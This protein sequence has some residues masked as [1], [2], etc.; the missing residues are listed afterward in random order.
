[1]ASVGQ[2]FVVPGRPFHSVQPLAHAVCRTKATSSLRMD[3][4]TFAQG[5]AGASAAG[6]ALA[7][8]FHRPA[9]SKTGQSPL[10][11]R[12]QLLAGVRFWENDLPG[13][14]DVMDSANVRQQSL[15]Q[16]YLNNFLRLSPFLIL[17]IFI[18]AFWVFPHLANFIAINS[19]Y[20]D[21]FSFASGRPVADGVLV[22]VVVPGLGLLFS[23]LASSTLG[24]LRQRLQEMRKL[25]RQE[26]ILLDTLCAPVQKLFMKDTEKRI[27]AT[28]LLEHYALC[29]VAEINDVK[30]PE[31]NSLGRLAYLDEE[32]RTTAQLLK[33]IGSLDMELLEEENL[34]RSMILGRVIGYAQGLVN[35]LDQR[36]ATRRSS[37]MFTF[38]LLHWV[39]LC[40]LA[41]SLPLSAVL[42]AATFK[43]TS[44]LI[45]I[46]PL[47]RVLFGVLSS[48]VSALLLLMADLN[49]PFAGFTRVEEADGFLT[50]VLTLQKEI[51]QLEAG[52][53][54]AGTP[55]S[56]TVAELAIAAARLEKAKFN[57]VS[58]KA[59]LG[60][61]AT[62]E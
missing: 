29:V 59:E 43:S 27:E 35:Q 21:S 10:R 47:V 3:A 14:G 36:R 55:S 54:S 57:S 37:F 52:R 42:L 11:S 16:I 4:Q 2:V 13:M 40:T 24:V 1:M 34:N 19:F 31:G 12:S 22:S 62:R 8:Q 20:N 6:G 44:T 46:D 41:L 15:Q 18:L 51:R 9:T 32:R 33:L 45:F 58:R 30:S 61:L 25:L 23:T 38:P 49:E 17:A 26:S 60:R 7:F 50:S 28:K 39:I 48:S 5:L 53:T 56:A